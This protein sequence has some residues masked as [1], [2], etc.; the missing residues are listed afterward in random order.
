MNAPYNFRQTLDPL[1]EIEPL[2]HFKA[3]P[4][5]FLQAFPGAELK[6]IHR[7]LPHR[8]SLEP[9]SKVI[10]FYKCTK[11]AIVLQKGHKKG[12]LFI[13]CIFWWRNR[14]F[15]LQSL[16]LFIT[17]SEVVSIEKAR[18]QFCCRHRVIA[19]KFYRGYVLYQFFLLH[20][21]CLYRL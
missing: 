9:R 2:R 19:K 8:I 12:F 21:K 3:Y 17:S 16:T 14:I 4:A 10:N 1:Q 13:L 11:P 15:L 6:E 7:C 20:C 18:G 5:L